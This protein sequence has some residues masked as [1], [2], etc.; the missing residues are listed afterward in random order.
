[1]TTPTL[2]TMTQR[3]DRLEREG[4]WWRVAGGFVAVTL[5]ATFLVGATNDKIPAEIKASRFVVVGPGGKTQAELGGLWPSL[6]FY[7]ANGKRLVELV[8]TGGDPRLTLQ[9]PSENARITLGV[10]TYSTEPPRLLRRL[11]TLR[12]WGHDKTEPVLTGSA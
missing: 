3:L 1:M 12:G 6:N 9:D 11:Q 7:D 2:D 8:I 5:A 10:K 4:R